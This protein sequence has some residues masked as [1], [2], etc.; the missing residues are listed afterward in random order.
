MKHEIITI[1]RLYAALYAGAM[2]FWVGPNHNYGAG[3][4]LVFLQSR[5]EFKPIEFVVSFV[6][7]GPEFGIT[8]GYAAL[9][10]KRIPEDV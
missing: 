5:G 9:G 3:D 2:N 6:L 4:V 8:P 10:L 7:Q 1:P